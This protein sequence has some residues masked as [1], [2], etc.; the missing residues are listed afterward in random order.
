MGIDKLEQQLID[1]KTAIIIADAVCPKI[2][3]A[4]VIRG[5]DIKIAKTSL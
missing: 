1:T 3:F 4:F 2:A 5:I